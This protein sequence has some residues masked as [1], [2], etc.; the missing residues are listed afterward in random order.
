MKF[1]LVLVLIFGFAHSQEHRD[2]IEKLDRLISEQ[3]AIRN[4]SLGV[5]ETFSLNV[6]C[7]VLWRGM[8]N[9]MNLSKDDRKSGQIFLDYV[10]YTFK[11]MDKLKQEL[12]F[13]H[14]ARL[15]NF[16]VFFENPESL[17]EKQTCGANIAIEETISKIATK[18]RHIVKYIFDVEKK[19]NEIKERISELKDKLASMKAEQSSDARGNLFKDLRE[20][21]QNAMDAITGKRIT[22]SLMNPMM[23]EIDAVRKF[24][25]KLVKDLNKICLSI[26]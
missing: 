12:R 17:T 9:N 16:R 3:Y 22:K 11:L 10:N 5:V 15:S 6:D 18:R 20:A 1:C 4:I 13:S 25:D 21:A 24:E 2:G 23:D 19:M 26:E 7:I 8:V 14:G